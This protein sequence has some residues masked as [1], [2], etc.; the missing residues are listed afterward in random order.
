[1]TR[2]RTFRF[3]L[4]LFI[5]V[6]A[7]YLR[8]IHLSLVPTSSYFIAILT[9]IAIALVVVWV[10]RAESVVVMRR[11]WT[12]V[13]IAGWTYVSFGFNLVARP[14][15]ELAI[16]FM[17]EMSL[18]FLIFIT[19]LT[20]LD[21]DLLQNLYR[22]FLWISSVAGVVLLLYPLMSGDQTVRRVGG[23]ELPGAVNNISTML[24]VG[25]VIALVGIALADDY[26]DATVEFV[27]LPTIIVG[28]MLSASRSAIIG[29]IISIALLSIISDTDTKRVVAVF[30][31]LGL[32]AF[33]LIASLYDLSGLSRFTVAGLRDA[34]TTRLHLYMRAILESGLHPLDLLFGGGMHR[35]S[36][37]AGPEAALPIDKII[38]PHNFVISLLVHIGLIAAV[39]FGIALVWNYR[40]LLYLSIGEDRSLDYVATT[41]LL[42]LI[43]I[44]MYVFTSGRITR[45]FPL[46]IFLAISEFV[47][48]SRVLDLGPQTQL[49]TL[50][51]LRNQSN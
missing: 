34:I 23:Y 29:L 8:G 31:S 3:G 40:S 30:G 18:N 4:L 25:V 2:F 35:Y 12:W 41:T 28:V 49:A 37:I 10:V 32:G 36:K 17:A 20:L 16:Q 50:S 6:N 45:T 48:T 38:Y 22:K 46:W 26:R 14:Y 42:S 13:A 43:V 19:F 24:A 44:S 9:T 39:V 15:P 21:E 33:I 1:M 11:W 51:G 27:A 7:A 47:Y 5:L